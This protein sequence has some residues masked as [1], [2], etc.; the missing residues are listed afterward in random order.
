ML[1]KS[2]SNEQQ[3]AKGGRASFEVHHFQARIQ[4]PRGTCALR[5]DNQ[6][7][8]LLVNIIPKYYSSVVS[9]DIGNCDSGHIIFQFFWGL[10][11]TTA[12]S[13]YFDAG[14]C[15]TT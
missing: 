11:P 12:V 5:S 7:Y 15:A 2:H 9:P 6:K 4:W 1:W 8:Y 14:G 3:L 13:P 10:G